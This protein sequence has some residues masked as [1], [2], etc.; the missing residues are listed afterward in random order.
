LPSRRTSS[1]SSRIQRHRGGRCRAF[2]GSRRGCST[3]AEGRE[4]QQVGFESTGQPRGAR[5]APPNLGALPA[6]PSDEPADQPKIG[7]WRS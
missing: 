4:V 5:H 7:D 6:G 3:Q 2:W 1:P